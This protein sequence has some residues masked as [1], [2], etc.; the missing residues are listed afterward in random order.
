MS[1]AQVFLRRFWFPHGNAL[2]H[3]LKEKHGSCRVLSNRC[4]CTPFGKKPPEKRLHQPPPTFETRK[5]IKNLQDCERMI[6]S[7]KFFPGRG[8]QDYPLAFTP[9]DRLIKHFS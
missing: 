7:S 8:L 6:V 1:R 3:R 2:T 5:R 4:A 9:N